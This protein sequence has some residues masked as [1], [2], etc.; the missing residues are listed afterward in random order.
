MRLDKFLALQGLGTRGEARALVRAGR[1][2]VDGEAAR[3][4]SVALDEKSACVTLDGERLRYRASLH[5]MMNKPAGVLTAAADSRRAT[6]MGLLPRYAAAMGCMPVGRLDLDTEGL[7]LF[8]TDGPLAHRLLSPGRRVEKLYEAQVDGTL[9]AED[10][11]AFGEGLVLS[12]FRA[13]PAELMI[14]PGAARARVTVRE[15]K[16]HQVKRMFQAR[17]K[18]VTYLKRLS[19]GGVWLDPSLK[20]GEWRELTDEEL[21]RLYKAAGGEKDGRALL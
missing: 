13:M 19:F 5:L 6:V 17:G 3:D 8:T 4:G 20:A 18:R 10:A 2:F 7:L 14:L 9:D 16:F 1:V 15:G 12:D 21:A 11:A